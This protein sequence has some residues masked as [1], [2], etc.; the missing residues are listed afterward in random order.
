M[1]PASSYVGTL[2]HSGMGEARG[3]RP[4]VVGASRHRD[5]GR[6]FG[7][8]GEISGLFGRISRFFCKAKTPNPRA[9]RDGSAS[10]VLKGAPPPP[11]PFV[12]RAM[13]RSPPRAR[14]RAR[15]R[16]LCRVILVAP[17]SPRSLRVPS[18]HL[19]HKR[20]RLAELKACP[21]ATVEAA[22]DVSGSV[23]RHLSPLHKA[24]PE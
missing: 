15:G 11:V 2:S 5:R 10:F 6:F 20:F 1:P 22:C 4:L 23:S 18:A 16:R 7:F 19:D 21:R 12:S 8:S 24:V 17:M 9:R 3:T 14:E 13:R